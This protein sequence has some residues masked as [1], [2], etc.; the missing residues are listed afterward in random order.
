MCLCLKLTNRKATIVQCEWIFHAL[1]ETRLFIICEW[2]PRRHIQNR[3]LYP[4]NGFK[5]LSRKRREQDSQINIIIQQCL[6]R[7]NKVR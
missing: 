4:G 1:A 3:L 5:T 6:L 2:V 7:I